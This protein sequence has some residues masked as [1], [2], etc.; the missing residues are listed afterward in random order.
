VIARCQQVGLPAPE[1]RQEGGQF[2]QTLGRSAPQV[3]AQ[4]AQVTPPVTPPVGKLLE[5]IADRVNWA[6]PRFASCWVSPIALI[7]AKIM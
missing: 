2:I 7:C 1:F 6:T 3:E 4:E 5:A